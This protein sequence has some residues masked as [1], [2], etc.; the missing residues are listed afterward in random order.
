MVF[1]GIFLLGILLAVGR[2][3]EDYQKCIDNCTQTLEDKVNEF[4]TS[5]PR[6]I[7]KKEEGNDDEFKSFLFHRSQRNWKTAKANVKAS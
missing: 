2:A 7:N 3:S 4:L 5:S 6:T 1:K